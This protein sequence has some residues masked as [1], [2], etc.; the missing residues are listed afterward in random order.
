MSEEG[1][2][3]KREASMKASLKVNSE[4]ENDLLT[5]YKERGLYI[6]RTFLTNTLSL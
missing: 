4:N 5:F 1:F 3:Q 2:S 6:G